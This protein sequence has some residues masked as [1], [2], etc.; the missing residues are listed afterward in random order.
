MQN[1]AVVQTGGKQYTVHAGDV[2]RVELLSAVNE[3]DS[4]ELPTIAMSNNGEL[5]VGK[6]ELEGKVKATILGLERGKKIVVFKWK[7]RKAYRKKVGHRQNYHSI[8]IESLPGI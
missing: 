4:V 2:L 3:G 6:P 7:K 5:V 1:Y 8:R